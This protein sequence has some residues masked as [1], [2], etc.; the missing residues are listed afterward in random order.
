VSEIR[1]ARPEEAELLAAVRRL[2]E[3]RGWREDG[4]TGVVEFP[5]NPLDVG[6]TLDF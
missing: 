5:P 6:Y 1:E 2:Y 3:C 4:E